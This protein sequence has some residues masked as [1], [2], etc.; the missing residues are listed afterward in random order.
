[1]LSHASADLALTADAAVKTGVSPDTASASISSLA[2][3]KYTVNSYST[4]ILLS[5]TMITINVIDG[6]ENGCKE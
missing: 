6:D 1:M 5:V 4:L 2:Y 3:E